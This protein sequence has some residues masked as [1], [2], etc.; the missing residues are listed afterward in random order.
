MWLETRHTNMIICVCVCPSIRGRSPLSR[1]RNTRH[2]YEPSPPYEG[3]QRLKYPVARGQSPPHHRYPHS[4]TP[5]PR[6]I[7]RSSPGELLPLML[8]LL[9]LLPL[10]LLLLPLLHLIVLLLHLLT[11][12]FPLTLILLL[13]LFLLLLMLLL[14]FPCWIE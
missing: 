1:P 4:P 11:L 9:P 8:L 10:M 5:P 13:L 3:Q 12:M 2:R 14:F 6:N 7:P